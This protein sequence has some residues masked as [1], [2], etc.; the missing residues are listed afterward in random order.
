MKTTNAST[1][2][3]FSAEWVRGDNGN[4]FHLVNP[5]G[6]MDLYFG[7]LHE[8]AETWRDTKIV[9]PSRWGMD[10]PPRSVVEF[11]AIAD[12]YANA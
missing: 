9:D 7:A 1:R 5:R 4:R 3:A 11:L 12:R 6:T 2:E 10:S 8:G